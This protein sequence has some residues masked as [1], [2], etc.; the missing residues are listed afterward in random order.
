MAAV[1]ILS[2][3]EAQEKKIC[4][5]FHFPPFYLPWSDG[6]DA[7]ILVFW[8]LRLFGTFLC[9]SSLV[10]VLTVFILSFSWSLSV[11]L[12]VLLWSLYQ[13][14]YLSLFCKVF[15]MKFYLFNNLKHT[16]LSPC[17][18]WL[19]VFVSIHQMKQLSLP[20]LKA[21]PYVDDVW[22]LEVPCL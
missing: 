13:L 8:M 1:S 19:S 16:L 6:T 22:G 10:E 11:S 21:W 12:W 2:E 5:Y 9:F 7:M 4:H 14:D 18:A 15:L 17:F 3:S 20:V